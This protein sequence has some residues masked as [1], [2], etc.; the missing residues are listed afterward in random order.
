MITLYFICLIFSLSFGYFCV[1]YI[2]Y[3]SYGNIR[4][5]NVPNILVILYV[6]L[7][8]IP[9][10]NIFVSAFCIFALL[11]LLMADDIS[12]SEDFENKFSI[13]TGNEIVRKIQGK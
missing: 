2:R 11:I 5:L 12:L 10:A 8:F 7:A 9:Y 3:D 13:Y 4:P 1:K 6:I